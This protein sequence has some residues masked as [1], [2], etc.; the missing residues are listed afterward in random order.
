MWPQSKKKQSSNPGG[1]DIMELCSNMKKH[2][3]SL[4]RNCPT[5]ID[6][7]QTDEVSTPLFQNA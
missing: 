5:T 1:Q 4:Q 6:R 7:P 2:P 3:R